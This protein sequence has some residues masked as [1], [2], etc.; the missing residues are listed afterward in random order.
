MAYVLG[1]R[2]PVWMAV[3][4]VHDCKG[5]AEQ[6]SKLLRVPD[7]LIKAA[8]VYAKAFP[9]EIEADREA[10]SRPIEELDALVPNHSF[11]RV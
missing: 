10:G 1:V 11:V 6:A 7:L 5:N 9:A 4:T 2:L 8:L 3:A